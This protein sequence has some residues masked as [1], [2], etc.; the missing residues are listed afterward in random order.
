MVVATRPMVRAGLVSSLEGHDDITLAAIAQTAAEACDLSTDLDLD[1]VVADWVGLGMEPVSLAGEI[2]E[3]RPALGVVVLTDVVD[4]A[5]RT[6]MTG[7]RSA[8]LNGS[9][10]SGDQVADAV[11]SV[12]AGN[13][14]IA[15]EFVPAIAR[16]V[17]GSEQPW[18]MLTA[19]ERDV[20]ALLAEGRTNKAIARELGL[21]PGT[22]SVY[23]STVLAKLGVT[24]RTE[25]VMTAVRDGQ[26]NPGPGPQ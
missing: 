25:A 22:I 3:P 13:A 26:L 11:R 19:R 9:T 17:D 18:A 4:E 24:N 1:V 23:V 14:V 16:L 8:C 2:D 6:V 10:V 21:Q 20:L 5:I 12:M 15:A 7:W